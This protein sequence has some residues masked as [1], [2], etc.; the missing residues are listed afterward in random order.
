MDETA[1]MRIGI[2]ADI[3]GNSPALELILP[4]L[5]N[6]VEKIMF[7]GDLCGY[8]PFV[9]ECLSL[10]DQ[11]RIIA[12]RGNHDEVL[13]RCIERQEPPKKEY[14]ESYGSALRRTLGNLSNRSV[15]MLKSLP[16]SKLLSIKGVKFALYHGSPWDPLE[17]R[18]YPDYDDWDR[19]NEVA[20]DIILLGHTHY[21]FVKYHLGKLIVNPGS[22]GQPRDY[23][24]RAC[25]AIL[26]VPGRT[27]EHHRVQFDPTRL[28]EDA[29]GHDPD[30]SYPVRVLTQR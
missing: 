15:S 13:V 14:E 10:W 9:E 5:L 4:S 25:F 6:Q 3:H 20:A 29:Q 16:L 11:E 17:G 7:L 1:I 28:I 27:I 18:V 12:V 26:E 8:Y 2:L 30:S 21:P 23:A 22:V 24:C 19:F